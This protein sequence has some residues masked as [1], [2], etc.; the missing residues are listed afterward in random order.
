M[1][2][3]EVRLQIL[4]SVTLVKILWKS[5]LGR[6]NSK[7]R[8]PKEEARKGNSCVA[9]ELRVKGD[10]RCEETRWSGEEFNV[11]R[12]NSK[13]RRWYDLKCECCSCCMNHGYKPTAG[14]MH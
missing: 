13:E 1:L 9:R 5:L 10:Q 7:C 3:T 4:K 8:G 12:K 2:K 14:R 11:Q 6:V